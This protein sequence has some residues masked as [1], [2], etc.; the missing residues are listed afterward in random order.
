MSD[1][2]ALVQW[3]AARDLLLGLNDKLPQRRKGLELARRC[4][5]DEAV[6]FCKLFPDVMPKDCE[7]I[8]QVFLTQGDDAKAL[9]FAAFFCP[10][11]WCDTVLIERSANMGYP[12]AQAWMQ[13]V[14]KFETKVIEIV[15]RPGEY[16]YADLRWAEKAALQH[17]PTGLRLVG[18]AFLNKENLAKALPLLLEA[19]QLGDAKAQYHY[20]RLQFDMY[21]P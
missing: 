12:F 10:N 4:K 1:E 16:E 2:D 20:G 13:Y 6:W 19:A 3:Y 7:T 9:C 8:Q 5:H 21:H 11:G 18:K 15:G 14:N 17:D